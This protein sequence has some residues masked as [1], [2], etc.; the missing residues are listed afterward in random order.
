[1]EIE[2]TAEG[3]EEESQAEHLL[4]YGCQWGQGYLFGRPMPADE[5]E[6]LFEP[7]GTV[8]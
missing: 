3:I 6:R 7:I 2:V 8:R 5:M 1:M 4:A